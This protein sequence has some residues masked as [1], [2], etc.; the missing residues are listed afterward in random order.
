[1]NKALKITVALVLLC[2]LTLSG[3]ISTQPSTQ[4]TELEYSVT[5]VNG[6][7]E[8]YTTGVIVKLLKNGEQVAMQPVSSAGT[9]EKKLPAGDYTVELQ[10]TGDA[11]D[12]YYDK[13][14]LT[15]SA[16]KRLLQ[17]QVFPAAGGEAVT[18]YDKNGETRAYTV[19]AGSTYVSLVDGVRNYF[20][21]TPETAGTY[22]FTTSDPKAVIGNYGYTHYIQAN[23]IAEVTDNTFTMSITKSMVGTGGNPF[24]IGVDANGISGCVLSIQRT[25]DP[26]YSIAEN[27]PWVIYK[28]TVELSPYTLPEGELKD[29]DITADSDAYTL[30]FNENDGTYHL[31]TADGPQV[32]VRLSKDT[33][34]LE[35][36]S[37]ICVTT[38]VKK[39]FYQADG[40]F[41]KREDYTEC[42]QTYSNVDKENGKPIYV[43]SKHGVYPLTE[44]LKYIIQNHG[45]YVGWWDPDSPGFLFEDENEHKLVGLNP[46][47]AWLF[48]CCYL[49]PQ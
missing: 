28:P 27:E 5:V 23:S 19:Q 48:V 15:L 33:K 38:G 22:V 34:Y 32:L 9:V 36:I 18:V 6:D 35:A 47:I 25:G 4:L 40:S 12:Y 37:K 14:D 2:A 10:F 41:L 29:F 24:V 1:M 11:A 20:L 31:N 42:L 8:P 46:D 7:G 39:Y 26:A 13:T 16:D 45:E 30:V 49:E 17:I 3:C 21:F 44:D 43:D